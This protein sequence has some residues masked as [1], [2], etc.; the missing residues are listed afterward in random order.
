[1]GICVYCNRDSG[2]K[3]RVLIISPLLGVR[4]FY[5]CKNC[6]YTIFGSKRNTTWQNKPESAGRLFCNSCG[7]HPQD[8]LYNPENKWTM[9]VFCTPDNMSCN[10]LRLCSSCTTM[11]IDEYIAK[12]KRDDHQLSLYEVIVNV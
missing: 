5:P 12:H 11:F 10:M 2:Y 6:T 1:M 3:G 7:T 4:S 8:P 9:V